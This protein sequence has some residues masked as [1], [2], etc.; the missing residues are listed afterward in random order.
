VIIEETTQLNKKLIDTLTEQYS[1]ERRGIHVSDLVSCLRKTVYEK[2][3]P[4]PLSET[5]LMLFVLGE[6]HHQVIQ[7]LAGKGEVFSE[8]KLQ[9]DEV[10]GTV[11][12]LDNG[13]P[14]EIKTR[15]TKD[16]EPEDNHL[17]QLSYYM[18]MIPSNVGLLLYVMLNNL[19]DDEPKFICRT[20][21]LTN[22]ELGALRDEL[23]HRKNLLTG[24]LKARNPSLAPRGEN[25]RECG[26]CQYFEGCNPQLNNFGDTPT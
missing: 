18:A 19:E 20:I 9:M 11:D 3:Q 25:R 24:A 13:V 7:L 8:Q 4:I 5:D 16:R 6:G 23:L 2:I 12:L 14:I 17:K 22:N 1:K 10:V 15:R 21:T 26:S